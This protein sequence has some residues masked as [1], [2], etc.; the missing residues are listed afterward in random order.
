MM[1]AEAKQQNVQH[2]VEYIPLKMCM[3]E[4]K[5]SILYSNEYNLLGN[6]RWIFKRIVWLAE[7]RIINT[8]FIDSACVYSIKLEFMQWLQITLKI[9]ISTTFALFI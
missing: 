9:H 5:A 6:Q 7:N 2:L 8:R 1:V 3:D 4:V